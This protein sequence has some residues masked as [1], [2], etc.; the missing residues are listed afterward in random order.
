MLA[1]GTVCRKACHE[2]GDETRRLESQEQ[3]KKKGSSSDGTGRNGQR[4][5]P[6]GGGKG[7]QIL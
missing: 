2:P 5:D 7:T 6:G 4:R 1:L 3:S